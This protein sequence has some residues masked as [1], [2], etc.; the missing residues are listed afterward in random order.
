[1]QLQTAV[2]ISAKS[3]TIAQKRYEVARNRYML[4]KINITDLGL[5]QDAKDNAVVE[6]V[7]TLQ[8]YWQSYYTLRL[9]TL[10]DFEKN[11][12]IEE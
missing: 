10:Y 5:A 4:G 6:Y 11:K 12:A 7:R 2:V 3:D 1:M 9:M 8:Q